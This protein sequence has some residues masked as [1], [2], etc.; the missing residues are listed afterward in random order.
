[1]DITRARE[2]YV[3]T[4][5]DELFASIRNGNPINNGGNGWQLAPC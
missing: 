4:E 1:M 2:T 3:Q 5:H